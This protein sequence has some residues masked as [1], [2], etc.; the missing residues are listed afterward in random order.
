MPAGS[1]V[2]R[3]LHGPLLAGAAA[4]T[5]VAPVATA[6]PAVGAA[7]GLAR[8]A[9]AGWPTG[10][11]VVMVEGSTG[12]GAAEGAGAATTRVVVDAAAGATAARELA[13]DPPVARPRAKAAPAITTTAA[14]AATQAGRRGARALATSSVRSL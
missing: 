13:D 12:A 10:A 6:R 1:V 14:A 4:S 5:S 7:G 3:K 9:T 8:A 11:G 2:T